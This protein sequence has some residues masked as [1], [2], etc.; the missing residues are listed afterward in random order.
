MSYHKSTTALHKA[1]A[2]MRASPEV[3]SAPLLKTGNCDLECPPVSDTYNNIGLSLGSLGNGEVDCTVLHT[4]AT[5]DSVLSPGHSNETCALK[6]GINSNALSEDSSKVGDCDFKCT[7]EI[8]SSSSNS[9]A[10]VAA[11]LDCDTS[12]HKFTEMELGEPGHTLSPHAPDSQSLRNPPAPRVF[13]TPPFSVYVR[14]SAIALGLHSP[15]RQSVVLPE[16]RDET[17]P[18]CRPSSWSDSGDDELEELEDLKAFF[19]SPTASL[20]ARKGRCDMA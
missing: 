4:T 12:Q 7:S 17:A 9:V 2:R 10:S 8:T 6:C 15:L 14:R 16:M 3:Q 5:P 20:S 19:D 13:D 1:V 11:S 18:A